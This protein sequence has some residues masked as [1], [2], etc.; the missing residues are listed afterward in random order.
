MYSN[1]LFASNN[2]FHC[3]FKI[4]KMI[5]IDSMTLSLY[6]LYFLFSFNIS[7]FTHSRILSV[8][9]EGLLPSPSNFVLPQAKKEAHRI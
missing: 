4:I 9:Q 8:Y 3:K 6:Y 2:I 7:L 1:I 5:L